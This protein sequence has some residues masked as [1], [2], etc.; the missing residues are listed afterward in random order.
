MTGGSSSEIYWDFPVQAAGQSQDIVLNVWVHVA[1]SVD[2]PNQAMRTF[3]DGALVPDDDL[4]FFCGSWSACLTVIGHPSARQGACLNSPESLGQDSCGQDLPAPTKTIA[5]GVNRYA[6]RGEG[7]EWADE[8]LA[9]P[10]K[11]RRRE[12]RHSI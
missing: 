12:K 2:V 1:L 5:T 6:C 3:I 7:L 10:A 4:A 11:E 9:E 8:D